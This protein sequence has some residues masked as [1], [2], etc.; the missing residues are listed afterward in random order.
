M[1]LASH[2]AFSSFDRLCPGHYNLSFYKQ[3]Y[4]IVSVTEESGDEER[5]QEGKNLEIKYTVLIFTNQKEQSLK[6]T[7]NIRQYSKTN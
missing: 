7:K 1:L 3:D 5:C 2:K 4:N 6:P